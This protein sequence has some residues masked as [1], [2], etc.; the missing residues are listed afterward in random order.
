MDERHQG[1]GEGGREGTGGERQGAEHDGGREV[2][3]AEVGEEVEGP[4]EAGGE[5]RG[6]GEHERGGGEGQVGLSVHLLRAAREGHPRRAASPRREAPGTLRCSLLPVPP[7][8]FYAKCDR[9]RGEVRAG[10]SG[11]PG[12]ARRPPGA[13]G[14]RGSAAACR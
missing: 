6:G 1:A 9:C 5:R 13:C 8:G 10:R 2:L 14:S 11:P 7:G 3:E 4:P 12:A